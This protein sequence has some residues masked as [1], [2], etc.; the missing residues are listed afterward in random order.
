MILFDDVIYN[1]YASNCDNDCQGPTCDN[2]DNDT[3]GGGCDNAGCDF[4]DSV[5]Y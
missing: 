5:N 3:T 2:C 4:C 1:V